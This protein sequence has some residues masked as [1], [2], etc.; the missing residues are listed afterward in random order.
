MNNLTASKHATNHPYAW[1]AEPFSKLEKHKC[2]LK[3]YRKSWWIELATVT[4]Q[5]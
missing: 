2:T 1:L 5:A 4:S 3:N